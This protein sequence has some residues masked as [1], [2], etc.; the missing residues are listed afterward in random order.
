M[1]LHY[2]ITI[3]LNPEELSFIML[4]KSGVVVDLSFESLVGGL[5]E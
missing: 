5:C 3:L 1:L 4:E 2:F